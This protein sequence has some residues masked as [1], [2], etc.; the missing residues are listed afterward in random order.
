MLLAEVYHVPIGLSL[1]VIAAILAVA[2][3]V[4]LLRGAGNARR[5]KA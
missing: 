1:G 2:V 5:R 4:S 3:G